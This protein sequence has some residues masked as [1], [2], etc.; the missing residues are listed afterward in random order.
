[1]ID[2][3]IDIIGPAPAG[4]DFLQYVFA[5]L[6]MFLAIFIVYKILSVFLAKII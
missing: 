5:G 4:L 1:M 3:I 2:Y 6:L